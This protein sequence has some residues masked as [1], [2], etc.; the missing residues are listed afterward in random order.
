MSSILP[1][2]QAKITILRTSFYR[3]MIRVVIFVLFRFVL[4]R[5]EDTRI[6]FR[7]LLTCSK[8]YEKYFFY[9]F[10]KVWMPNLEWTLGTHLCSSANRNKCHSLW[11]EVGDDK[12]CFIDRWWNLSGRGHLARVLF[13][14]AQWGMKKIIAHCKFSPIKRLSTF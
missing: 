13:R 5:I 9:K 7:D 6:C 4:G 3:E 11:Q 14:C 8:R 12:P 1:K 2:K 10:Q